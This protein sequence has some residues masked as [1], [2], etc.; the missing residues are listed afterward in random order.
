MFRVGIVLMLLFLSCKKD[1]N[2]FSFFGKWKLVE[3]Y[4]G[5]ITTG[6][7][8]CWQD[9]ATSAQHTV[10]F[11]SDGTYVLTQ[12]PIS[13]VP[14]CTGTYIKTDNTLRWTRCGP[15]EI[16]VK[17]TWES[18]YLLLEEHTLNGVYVYK[19]KRER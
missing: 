4:N 13:S 8:S 17:I 1:K 2:D 9:A 6:G 18:P 19:Y 5:T 11:R 10:E 14:G 16:E 3:V 12:S 7:C 15:G